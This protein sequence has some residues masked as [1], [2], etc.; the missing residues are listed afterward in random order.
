M[1]VGKDGLTKV[2]YRALELRAAS[3][4]EQR[5]GLNA[6]LASLAEQAAAAQV[7]LD[8]LDA[9]DALAK[10]HDSAKAQYETDFGK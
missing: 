10:V 3:R 5:K 4:Q 1:A 9:E 8:L 6:K 7:E 2:Q